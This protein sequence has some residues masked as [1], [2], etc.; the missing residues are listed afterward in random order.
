MKSGPVAEPENNGRVMRWQKKLSQKIAFFK[1]EYSCKSA[2]SN[3]FLHHQPEFAFRDAFSRLRE[4]APNSRVLLA[5]LR[6]AKVTGCGKNISC[7]K[8]VNGRYLAS[9]SGVFRQT[10]PDLK[11]FSTR[12]Q[13]GRF[14]RFSGR[15]RILKFGIRGRIGLVWDTVFPPLSG[16]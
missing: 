1:S 11:V 15:G 6:V 13:T 16:S 3:H 8:P 10:E 9:K 2:G 7:C 4:N 5:N 14:T 12:T